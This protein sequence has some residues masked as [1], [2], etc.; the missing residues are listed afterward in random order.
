MAKV[1]KSFGITTEASEKLDEWKVNSPIAQ[2]MLIEML[3]RDYFGMDNKGVIL[4]GCKT[5]AVRRIVA[6]NLKEVHTEAEETLQSIAEKK[7]QFFKYCLEEK[8]RQGYGFN[9]ASQ[10]KNVAPFKFQLT[11]VTPSE[12]EEY[13]KE[14]GK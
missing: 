4:S 14:N 12:V 8:Q 2:S 11:E 10:V 6:T 13:I 5:E 7:E 3:I 9:I 1:V